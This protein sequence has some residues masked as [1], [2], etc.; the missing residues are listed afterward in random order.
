MRISDWSSDV[1]SSDLITQALERAAIVAAARPATIDGDRRRNWAEVRDRVARL[2]GGLQGLGVKPGDR[3]AV[4][5]MNCD[6]FFEAYFAI[7]WA[8]AV[9]VPLN[10]RL[11]RS[12]EHTSELQS[13]MRIAYALFYFKKKQY[14]NN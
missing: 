7:P 9:L 10:T 3:V 13:L 11:A 2:A 4:L 8:G 14:R 6:T 1:C 5:A 12:E